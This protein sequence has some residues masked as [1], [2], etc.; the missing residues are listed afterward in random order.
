VD[1]ALSLQAAE[2]AEMKEE[3][4]DIERSSMAKRL[5]S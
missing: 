4:A 3:L 1:V 5:D 2:L